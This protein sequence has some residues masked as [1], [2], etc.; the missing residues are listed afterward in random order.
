MNLYPVYQKIVKGK[1]G[2]GE[3]IHETLALMIWFILSYMVANIL[4]HHLISRV[5]AIHIVFTAVIYVT[6][7]L[8]LDN[9]PNA[10]MGTIAVSYIFLPYC[11]EESENAI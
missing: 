7:F 10:L 4:Y 2:S 5:N 1:R 9:S 6:A 8:V 3:M 11:K